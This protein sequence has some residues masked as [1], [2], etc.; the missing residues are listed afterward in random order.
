MKNI[1]GYPYH[2]ITVAH[3]VVSDEI[4]FNQFISDDKFWLIVS[5]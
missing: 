3:M 2:V 5:G 4:S 1:T